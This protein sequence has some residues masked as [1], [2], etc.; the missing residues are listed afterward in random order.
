MFVDENIREKDF[1]HFFCKD[2]GRG[3]P[4]ITFRNGS[5]L[6]KCD[7]HRTSVPSLIY[8]LDKNRKELDTR[9]PLLFLFFVEVSV[10]Q[11]SRKT[12]LFT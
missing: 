2:I 11:Y 6:V 5:S 3:M 10:T 9:Y 4:T 1:L 7:A 8:I 12:N